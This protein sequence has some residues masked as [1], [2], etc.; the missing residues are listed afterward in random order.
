[1]YL[2]QKLMFQKKVLSSRRQST[3]ARPPGGATSHLTTV[4]TGRKTKGRTIEGRWGDKGGREA[5]EGRTGKERK[6]KEREGK[7]DN[8]DKTGKRTNQQSINQT[9]KW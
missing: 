7:Q 8:E 4:T 6:R 3:P 2:S 5:K 1:M 9:N